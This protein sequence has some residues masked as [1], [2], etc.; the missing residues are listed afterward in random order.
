MYFKTM[1]FEKSFVWARYMT[2]QTRGMKFLDKM[3][4]I[5]P[6][7]IY[8]WEIAKARSV[9][10][11]GRPAYSD[12]LMIKIMCLA[13]WYNLSDPGMEDAIHDR[14]SFQKFLDIDVLWDSI[15]DETTILKFRH[16]ME[17]NN[18]QE[19][20][21]SGINKMLEEKWLLVREGTTVDATII[22][23]PSS[24]K[25]KDKSRDP[26]MHSTKKWNQWYFGMKS[27]IWVDSDSGIVHSLTCT[28]AN[29]H[30]SVMVDNLVHGKEKKLYGDSAYY[31]DER[32]NE[33]LFW[34]KLFCVQMRAYRNKPLWEFEKACNR[35]F[36]STRSKVEHVFW[37]IKNTWW[38]HKVR[39]RW[40]MK[41]E[42]QRYL[43]CWLANIWRMREQLA[44]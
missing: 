42:C 6:W 2:I 10:N 37:V 5:M 16:F 11:T 33:R 27:H 20:I 34:G 44:I 3:N 19:K 9:K 36:S 38:H 29:V 39:Y 12:L 26:D 32:R 7:G 31:S 13:Q 41:N 1:S 40:L 22:T 21:F 30:D 18:L 8:V 43:L 17:E 24:T 23:A 25:N 15:P 4:E 28:W 35:V 14:V